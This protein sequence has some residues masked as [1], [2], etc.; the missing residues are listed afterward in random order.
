MSRSKIWIALSVLILAAMLVSACQPAAATP[1]TIVQTVVSEA[2]PQIIVATAEPAEPTAEE[3]GP[4]TKVLNLSWGPGDIP[5]ID[6]AL[7]WDMIS[8]QIVDETTVGLTRQNEGTAELELAMATESTVSDDGLTYTFKLRDDIPWVKFDGKEVVQVVDCEGNPRMVTADDFAYGMLRTASPATAADYAYLLN[9]TIQGAEA[10]NNGETEDPATVGVKAID[11]TTLEIKFIKPAVYNL[12]I[13]GLWFAHAMPKWI[14]EGDDCTEG[15]GEKWVETGFYQGYGPFTLKEWVHDSELT[16][17]KNPFW[18]G[19]EVVPTAKI[20]ELHWTLIDATPALAEYEAGNLD[21][22]PIPSGDQDRIFADAEYSKQ[23]AP[24]YTLGTEFYSFNTLLA[25]TD[26]LRVRQALSMSIDRQ[27]LIDNVTKGGVDARWMTHPGATGGPK[28]EQYTG[29]L[30]I[31]YDPEAAKALIEEYATEKGITPADISIILMFNTAESHKKRAEAI[32][33][34]WQETLGIKVEL[35]NQEWKVF[36][37]SRTQGDAHVYRSTWVQDYP[38]ANNF[39]YEVF[40]PGGAYQNVT[41]WPVDDSTSEAYTDENFD[42]FIDLL[43]QAA[44]ETD[45]AKRMDLYAQAEQILVVDVAAIAPLHWYADHQ[46]IKPNV[47]WTQSN[48]G[49]ERYEKWDI[50]E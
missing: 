27:G 48:T 2:E 30:G 35:I 37:E 25:P 7:A 47:V 20:D 45:P 50:T 33:Q 1:Q 14:I 11:P 15:R 23:L 8:I 21:V 40:G 39:L 22:S 24:T 34:M 9:M 10:Y 43:E 36:R 13:A 42:K 29:E 28:P 16:L 44:V 17:I 32:Q 4:T 49:Y 19:D 41:D 31:E 5:T 6:S 46:L 3:T 26:D 18:P 38:D 12:N